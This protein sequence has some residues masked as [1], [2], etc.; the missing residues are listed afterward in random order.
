MQEKT[1]TSKSEKGDRTA[2]SDRFIFRK[3]LRTEMTQHILSEEL[4]TLNMAQL[5]KS[6]AASVCESNHVQCDGFESRKKQH[7]SH[8]HQSKQ[9]KTCKFVGCQV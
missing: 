6:L 5:V 4:P 7:E 8:F 3:T 2:L 1:K 9:R